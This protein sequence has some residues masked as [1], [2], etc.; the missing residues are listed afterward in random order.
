MPAALYERRASGR[1]R[2]VR[3]SLLSSIIGR[4]SRRP[5]CTAAVSSTGS[6]PTAGT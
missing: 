4:A 5:S 6:S 3:T 2:V 1:G